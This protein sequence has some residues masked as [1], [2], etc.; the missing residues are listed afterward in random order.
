MRLPLSDPD[1]LR[2]HAFIAGRWCDADDGT[3]CE[4]RNPANGNLLGTVMRDMQFIAY[5]CMNVPPD[6]ATGSIG[7]FSGTAVQTGPNSVEVCE[8]GSFC[9]TFD[10]TDINAANILEATTNLQQNLPGATFSTPERTRSRA[11]CAGTDNP[12]RRA[13]SPSS[14][15]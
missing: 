8:S 12:G 13:S 11:R 2:E 15:R 1:L 4:V 5:P 6:P 9:M 14:Y 3:R 10:I 7:G